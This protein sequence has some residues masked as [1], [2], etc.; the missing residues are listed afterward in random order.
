MDYEKTYLS[1]PVIPI[2]GNRI[3][4]VTR[5][6]SIMPSIPV[7]LERYLRIGKNYN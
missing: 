2:Y 5:H 6:G 1:V 7:D 4:I 3:N